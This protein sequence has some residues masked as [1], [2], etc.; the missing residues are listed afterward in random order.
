[1]FFLGTSARK[2]WKYFRWWTQ[3]HSPADFPTIP[4]ILGI[5]WDKKQT[6]TNISWIQMCFHVCRCMYE[7]LACMT[8]AIRHTHSIYIRF[9][10]LSNAMVMACNCIIQ[11]T[12][13]YGHGLMRHDASLSDVK[14]VA[15]NNSSTI[16]SL[17]YTS[18]LK[19]TVHCKSFWLIFWLF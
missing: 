7:N 13:R 10:V 18:I 11:H 14:S 16:W 8:C 15:H 1:M 3:S 17:L 2:P 4:M 19:G 12:I 9:P 5:W 6:T